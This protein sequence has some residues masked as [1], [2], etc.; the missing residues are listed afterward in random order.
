MDTFAYVN[1]TGLSSSG[2]R[3]SLK[4]V[5]T[6][7]DDLQKEIG[8]LEKLEKQLIEQRQ[9]VEFISENIK[10]WSNDLDTVERNS[11]GVPFVRNIK[12]ICQRI[13]TLL[14]DIHGDFYFRMQNLLTADVPCFQQVYEGLELLKKMVSK[15]LRDDATYKASFI[16]EMRQLFGRLIGITDTMLAVYFEQ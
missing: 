3:V 4:R 7:K 8:E 16:E 11:Q 1:G 2:K 13:E 5:V 9:D 14:T 10:K 6:R 12:E 15:I